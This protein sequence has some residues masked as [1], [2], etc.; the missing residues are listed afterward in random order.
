MLANL[1]LIELTDS[2]SGSKYVVVEPVFVPTNK[3]NFC[4]PVIDVSNS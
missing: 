1:A 4:G 2:I 3:A